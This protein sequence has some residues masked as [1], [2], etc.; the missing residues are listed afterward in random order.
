M[1]HCVR[2][3]SSGLARTHAQII[4]LEC[5]WW[6]DAGVTVVVMAVR[7]W[8][9]VCIFCAQAA[10]CERVSP[11]VRARAYGDYDYDVSECVA[12]VACVRCE[13]VRLR[14]IHYNMRNVGFYARAARHGFSPST[15]TQTHTHAIVICTHT[16]A[17]AVRAL[18][19]Y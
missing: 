2:R 15:H 8:C 5:A 17:R 10:T 3:A 4:A 18:C 6:R 1:R 11:H 19:G 9:G 13:C 7:L 12:R 16:D 14:G